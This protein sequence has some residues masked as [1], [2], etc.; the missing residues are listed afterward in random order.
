MF[1]L[2]PPVVLKDDPQQIQRNWHTILNF[3]AVIVFCSHRNLEPNVPSKAVWKSATANCV[4]YLEIKNHV[5]TKPLTGRCEYVSSCDDNAKKHL[6]EHP[7]GLAW[8][9]GQRQNRQKGGTSRH[10]NGPQSNSF[11]CGP[12]YT[13][14]WNVRFFLA[15]CYPDPANPV[16]SKGFKIQLLQ[17]VS[18]IIIIGLSSWAAP[19]TYHLCHVVRKC[20]RLD[21]RTAYATT[22]PAYAATIGW[23]E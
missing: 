16:A 18:K 3:G 22:A 14:D 5:G 21:L 11:S 8:R 17:K 19:K 12:I 10:F 9:K 20:L 6:E 7:K 13:S 23:Y 15:N 2:E 4:F 1:S